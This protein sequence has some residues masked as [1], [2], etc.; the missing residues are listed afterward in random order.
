MKTFKQFIT[1][2]IATRSKPSY[3]NVGHPNL[4]HIKGKWKYDNVELYSMPHGGDM[5]KI[6]LSSRVDTHED[7]KEVQKHEKDKVLHAR[8]RID[9][10]KK[11]YSVAVF[12]PSEKR[13]PHQK[14]IEKAFDNVHKYMARH[15]SRYKGHEFGLH[16]Y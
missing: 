6:T 3:F 10:Q 12:H 2:A 8:G 16:Y 4:D 5:V 11:E 9:H 7:W 1:E 14:I 15:H 13:E